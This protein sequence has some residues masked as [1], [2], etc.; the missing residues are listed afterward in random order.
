MVKLNSTTAI[1][2]DLD[3]VILDLAY[4]IKFWELWLPEQVANQTNKSIEETKAEIKAEIDIQRG[5]LNFYDLNYWDDLLNV[6]CMQIFKE[7]TERCSYLRGSYEA[8][9]RLSTLKNP[10]YIL[11]NGDPRIQDYKAET[12]NFLEFFDSIFYS[13]HVGYPKESKEFWALARHNL[14]LDFE[15]TI[16]IDDDFK[17]VTAAAKAG[18]K[19]VAWIT[20]G[21]NRILQ[22]RVETFASLSDLVST[23]T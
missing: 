21:K 19:Q 8:L 7:K 5:T 4:D 20:P 1:L 13:M 6:D 3:G 11:T 23:I 17:V 9:Q 15:D 18:I 12:Q 16:F 2:S 14:N 10:K 22:N